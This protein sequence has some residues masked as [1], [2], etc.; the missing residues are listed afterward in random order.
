MFRIINFVYFLVLTLLTSCG[1]GYYLHLFKGQLNVVTSTTDVTTFRGAT[2]DS[3]ILRKLVIVDSLLVFAN[4]IGLNT[5]NNYQSYFDTQGEPISWNVSAS[6]PDTF[7]S[8]LW[9][10][11]FV[12]SIPYKGF[13]DKKRAQSEYSRLKKLNY[14]VYMA[15]ISAYSTL[16]YFSDPLLSTMLSLE[17][18]NLTELLLH[19]LTHSTVYLSG[20]TDF[21]ESFAS[22]VGRKGAEQF[23]EQ[24]FGS[25]SEY[26]QNLVQS[27]V[28][29]QRFRLFMEGVVDRLDSLY[30]TESNVQEVMLKRKFIFDKEKMLF[31]KSLH[32]YKNQNYKNFL[33]WD[34]NN[35]RL[36][37]YKR[38]NSAMPNFQAVYENN[39]ESIE[40]LISLAITCSRMK[41]PYDCIQKTFNLDI[42]K[43]P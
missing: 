29:L 35:A 38:Y 12:G 6:Q 1:V 16:G 22:F 13:F 28:D 33:N 2:K 17:I 31:S 30:S 27:R 41:E 15:P 18:G 32:N 20:M 5:R 10:F 36:L 23:L 21:N 4:E 25:R 9:E 37:S 40:K 19:E 34:L 11:P 26:F 42:S 43:T 3:T 7:K 14:D 8:Y 39:D 24:Q